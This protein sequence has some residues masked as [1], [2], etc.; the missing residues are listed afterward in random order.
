MSSGGASRKKTNPL[1]LI[2]VLLVIFLPG[3]LVLVSFYEPVKPAMLQELI[4]GVMHGGVSDAKE[5]VSVDGCVT[6]DGKPGYW[7]VRRVTRTVRFRD[8]SRLV[9]TYSEPPEQSDTNCP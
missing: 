2:I 9:I 5:Q 8:G 6:I 7:A 3:S 1:L 4:L